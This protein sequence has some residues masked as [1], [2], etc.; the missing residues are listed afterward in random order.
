MKRKGEE[1]VV[2]NYQK[3]TGKEIFCIYIYKKRMGN[4]EYL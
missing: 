1:G 2:K 4:G 3:K